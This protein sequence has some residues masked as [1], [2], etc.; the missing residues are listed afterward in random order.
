M[1]NLLVAGLLM[2]QASPCMPLVGIP[3]PSSLLEGNSSQRFFSV[4]QQ[5]LEREV[6][7]LQNPTPLLEMNLSPGAERG[8]QPSN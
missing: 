4:G 6:C 7:A 2:A 8:T 3:G 5:R 1:T